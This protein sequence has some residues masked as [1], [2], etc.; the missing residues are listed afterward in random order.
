MKIKSSAILILFLLIAAACAP[1]AAPPAA[2]P[3]SPEPPKEVTRIVQGTPEVVV[4]TATPAPPQAGQATSAPE[5]T[6][7]PQPT[8]A[9]PSAPTPPPASGGVLKVAIPADPGLW[10]PK[11]TS[12]TNGIRAEAQ[13]YATLMKN[14]ADAKGVEP[15]LAESYEASPDL[16]EVTFHLHKDAKFCDGSPITANDVKFSFDRYLEKDSGVS[17]QYPQGTKVEVPDDYTVK[18]T[19]EVPSV[20]FLQAMT[21]WGTQIMSQKYVS[22]QSKDD[23]AAKPLGSGPFCLKSWDKG[24]GYVLTRNPGYWDKPAW[25]DEVDA[26]VIQDDTARVLQLESG[27]VDLVIDVPYNQVDV[28]SRYPGIHGYTSSL[29]GLASIVMNQKAVP[30]FKDKNVRQAM[31]YAIDRQALVDAVL[32]GKGDPAWSVWYGT[33]LPCYTADFAHKFDLDKAK[34]LMAQSTAPNGFKTDLTV[35]AGDTVGMQTAVILKDQL[36]KIGVDVNITPIE[37]GSWF[38]NWSSYNYQML[39]KLG[40]ELVNDQAQTI[41]FDYLT[42]E[43][44]G[45]GTAFTGWS[46]PDVTRVS[47]AALIEG[48]P[49]KRCQIY[50]DLQKFAMDQTPQLVLFHPTNRWGSSDKVYNFSINPTS[51]YRFWEVWKAPQ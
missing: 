8:P 13:I 20:W 42:V 40:T 36:S 34:Q 11:F 12:D 35:V 24:T 27:N 44:G 39:Y 4:I 32:F 22:A 29:W 7:A 33:D 45:Q 47:K 23:I 14:T 49:A 18:I 3:S 48:D 15:W 26:T 19:S 37:E 10:D 5:P 6:S 43:D 2:P 30:E 1:V 50:Y 41:P 21:L 51:L 31:S 46:D 25:V 28:L 16:K 38:S 9:Q 17:W